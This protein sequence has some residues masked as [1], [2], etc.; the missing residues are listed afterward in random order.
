MKLRSLLIVF[1]VAA[2]TVGAVWYFKQAAADAPAP[3]TAEVPKPAPATPAAPKV[4]STQIEAPKA[5]PAPKPVETPATAAT[6]AATVAPK[7]DPQAELGTAIDDIT[8][9]LQAGNFMSLF[10]KY[11]SPDDKAKM[12][13]EEKAQMEQEMSQ[14]ATDPEA[15][16]MLQMMTAG[17]QS[18]KD[19]VPQMNAAGD[20]ATYQMSINLPAGMG[21]PGGGAQTEPMTFQKVD[22]KWYI[23]DGP[24]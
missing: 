3:K 8:T 22:G 9:M 10:D 5:Q 19:Q 11:A 4:V 6:T 12:S 17:F 21:P 1:I 24:M 14:M 20:E 18:I 16:M 7:G 15:Q 23:K 2:L 13:P